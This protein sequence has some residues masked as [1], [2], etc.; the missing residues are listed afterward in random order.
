VQNCKKERA[1]ERVVHSSFLHMVFDHFSFDNILTFINKKNIL[2]VQYEFMLLCFYFIV[3][4]NLILKSI[5]KY[6]LKAIKQY[7]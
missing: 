2:T 3:D 6:E 4:M 1:V 5:E 7:F